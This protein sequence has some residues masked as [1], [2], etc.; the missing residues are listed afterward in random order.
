MVDIEPAATADADTIRSVVTAAFDSETE[1]ELVDVLREESAL[2]PDCSLVARDETV[3]GYIAVSEGELPAA[4]GLDVAI[5][6]PVGVVP[7]R[8]GEGIGTELVRTAMRRCVQ[9]GGDAV[10]VEG[11]PIWYQQFGFEPA[12]TYGIDSDLDPAEEAFLVW[13]C[14]PGALSGVEGTVRHPI[15]FHAL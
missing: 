14:K 8:Q 15:P 1:A 6:G 5:L 10:V 11:D 9:T 12:A 2:R 13:P 3:V 4:P 7:D